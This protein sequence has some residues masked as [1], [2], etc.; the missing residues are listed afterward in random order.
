MDI[1]MSEI[2]H[3]PL[4]WHVVYRD[5]CDNPPDILDADN[6]HVPLSGRTNKLAHRNSAYI[7]LAVNSH[8]KLTAALHRL[9]TLAPKHDCT[10]SDLGFVERDEWREAKETARKLLGI[11]ETPWIP[12]K[13]AA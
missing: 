7:I 5:D 13:G 12:R 1:R 2:A 9:I 11:D 6:N 10:D 3:T 4:P 8:D